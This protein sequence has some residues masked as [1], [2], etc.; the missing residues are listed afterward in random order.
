MGGDVAF[1][2]LCDTAMLLTPDGHGRLE[3]TKS[4][5]PAAF[6]TEPES[7]LGTRWVHTSG[8]TPLGW[9]QEEARLQAV[10]TAIDRRALGHRGTRVL[11]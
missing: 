4:Y 2:S 3:L 11:G 10:T 1:G 9:A 6:G 7:A 8:R 5:S